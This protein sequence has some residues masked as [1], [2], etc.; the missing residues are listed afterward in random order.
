MTALS[1]RELLERLV[2]FDSVSRNSN[3]P[4]A[5]FVCEYLDHPNVDIRCLESD[6]GDKVNV[7]VGT[8]GRAQVN[9]KKE[10]DVPG[11]VLSGHLDVVPADEPDWESDPFEVTE[12]D[13]MLFGRGTADMKGFVA[14][15]IN[16]F[17]KVAERRPDAPLM[18]LLTRDEELGTIGAQ[19]WAETWTGARLPTDVLVGE[20]TRLQVVTM[21]K[22]FVQLEINFHGVSAHS[23]YPHLGRSAIEPAG[24]A[25]RALTELRK[26]LDA[27]RPAYSEHFPEVP[28]AAL[29]IGMI[30]G[31]SAT[32]VVPDHCSIAVGI[33]LLPTMT[34]SVMMDRVR[35]ALE[36]ALGDVPFTLEVVSDSPPM[37]LDGETALSAQ[38]LRALQ[39]DQPATVSYATDAGWFQTVGHRCVIFG[40]GS[41]EVAHKPNEFLPI[42]EFERAR[43]IL[44]TIIQ[45][46]ASSR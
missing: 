1:D 37:W 23:G 4:I 10:G 6:D 33:R 38:L 25:V 18:L 7:L 46:I 14:L 31:G 45:P 30:N 12:R 24:V 26:A 22:G 29:N 13:G 21:H 44:D 35:A 11:L 28:F 19:H 2:A 20:P 43:D 5:D 41:I 15:A 27:E 8:K 17:R 36:T 16:T 34:G 9:G 40:P 32:N 39:Q 3:R 42:D